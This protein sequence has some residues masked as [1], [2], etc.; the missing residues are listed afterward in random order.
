MY[1]PCRTL[2]GEA[3]LAHARRNL[4]RAQRS[5]LVLV[6]GESSLDKLLQDAAFDGLGAHH[7]TDLIERGLAAL[8]PT[9][10]LARW[11]A[12]PVD[13]YTSRTP[14][15]RHLARR[16]LASQRAMRVHTMRLRAPDVCGSPRRVSATRAPVDHQPAARRDVQ[17]ALP[18]RKLDEARQLVTL[19]LQRV[20]PL[21]GVLTLVRVHRARDRQALRALLPA[22][23]RSL[24][25]QTGWAPLW[26]LMRRVEQLLAA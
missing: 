8:Q 16:Q 1:I 13:A 2:A 5:M 3:E 19:A 14:L 9:E 12:V 10:A 23:R 4:S 17:S 24:S 21:R 11:D 25:G 20:A 26:P 7:L 18:D 15:E 22:V 6:D